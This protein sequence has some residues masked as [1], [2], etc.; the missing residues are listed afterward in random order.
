MLQIKN[1]SI[2]HSKDLRPLLKD[3]SFTLGEG[4]KAVIIGEEGNGKSTLLKL[5]YQDELISGYAEYTGEVIK[6][7]LRL[8]YLAQELTPGQKR[9]TILEYCADIPAFYDQTPKELSHIAL[10]LGMKTEMFYSDQIVG[11][12]SGGEKVKLQL[13]G[14]LIEQPH[15]LL[16]DEPSNDLDI[17][18]L[19]W[20]E[21]FINTCGKPVL[22]VSH[23]ET[24]IENTA[25]VII[26]IEQV[27]RKTLPRYTVARMPY[28]Q[29]V[30]ER[31]SKLSHQEQAARKE[32]SEYNKQQEKFRQIQAKVEHQ[33]NTISRG[34]PH[35][36]QLLK[37]K[38]KAV[39][40][41]G[42]RFERE[43]ADMTQMPDVEDSIMIKFDETIRVPNGKTVLDFRLDQLITGQRVLA[44][45]IQLTVAG[46]EKLCII[47]A[48]GAGKTTLLRIIAEKLLARKDIEAAY[49]PQNYEDLLDLSVS[50]VTFL[51]KVGDKDEITKI[52]TFLGSL[53]YTADEMDHTICELS[54]GQKAKLLFLKMIFAGSNVLILDEP[55]RN[56]SPLSGPVIRDVLRA[57]GGAII[58]VSH[59]RKY[60]S[61]V[62]DKVYTLTENGLTLEA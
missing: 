25:N 62:C 24:L 39:T 5:I 29:Y 32:H 43:H 56:F 10:Q 21:H 55:T 37:K 61:E 51:S 31:L 40:S 9:R 57:Y 59:D 33:L 12:L 14:L 18:T 15:I 27:R 6:N 49:M 1:L 20:L 26:H 11:T 17:E 46:P 3:F 2:I 34:D 58:S 22:F 8:G 7:G 16:L 48:N 4:D 13:A 19:E 41:M 53:Q 36:G 38:M 42:K 52:R 23:D 44:E 30:E 50:P 28:R 60:I 54:G 35:G 47:G 45:N